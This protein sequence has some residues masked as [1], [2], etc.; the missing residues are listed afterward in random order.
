[1]ENNSV[2]VVLYVVRHGQTIFNALNK[3][4]GWSDTPLT[5]EG[6]EDIKSLGRGLK[7]IDFA[8][9]YSSDLGRTIKTAR[10][11]LGEKGQED[12]NIIE[13]ENL[14]ES[15]FGIYEG[16]SGD[17][18][19]EDAAKKLGYNSFQDML[20][21]SSHRTVGK[22]LSAIVEADTSN[23]AECIHTVRKRVTKQLEDLA[24]VTKKNG[25]GNVLV[26]SHGVSI[27][28]FVTSLIEMPIPKNG[29][30]NG[31]VTKVRYQDG[32]F[33]I[34]EFNEIKYI[35]FGRKTLIGTGR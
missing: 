24:E 17:E 12:L 2:E 9:A 10:I 19:W 23:L 34:E 28:S 5:I 7:D 27:M 18:A 20:E 4:Q 30:H 16:I 25:G 31:S 21:E 35:E 29:L 32:Q 3:M 15:C 22:M 13:L 1:M 33:I 14:R 8:A 11:I 26:V 6:A